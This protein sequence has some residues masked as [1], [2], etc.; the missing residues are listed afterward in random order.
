MFFVG[1]FSQIVTLWTGSRYSA[2]V[3]YTHVLTSVSVKVVDI[4]YSNSTILDC[5]LNI[6]T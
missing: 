3:V 5:S 6:L 1:I 4:Y 2:C